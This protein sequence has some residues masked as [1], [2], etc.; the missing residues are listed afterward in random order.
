VLPDDRII[1][2]MAQP[3][4][5]LVWMKLVAV[6]ICQKVT[7]KRQKNI[8]ELI[9][10]KYFLNKMETS[11]ITVNWLLPQVYKCCRLRCI[12]TLFV[13]CG[14]EVFLFEINQKAKK[15]VMYYFDTLS[16]IFYKWELKS[17]R[18]LNFL[19]TNSI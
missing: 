2:Y 19:L 15:Q 13:I 7:Q 12:C 9:Y 18:S 10:K 11:K 4:I 14:A 6:C 3:K 5:V 8:C 16:F 17:T 1:G